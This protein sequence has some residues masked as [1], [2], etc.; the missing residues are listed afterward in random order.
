MNIC[1]LQ[2][3]VQTEGGLNHDDGGMDTGHTSTGNTKP[4][5]AGSRG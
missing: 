1:P 4:F 5:P 3:D 2:L